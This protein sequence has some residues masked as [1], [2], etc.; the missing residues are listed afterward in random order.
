[1]ITIFMYH[2][3]HMVLQG[4]KKTCKNIFYILVLG[5][6]LI[7]GQETAKLNGFN[8]FSCYV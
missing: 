7:L 1:M 8:R 4:T 5:N 3:I 2:A 6:F